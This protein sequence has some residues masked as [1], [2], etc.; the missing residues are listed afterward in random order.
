MLN[1]LAAGHSSKNPVFQRLSFIKATEGR[2]GWVDKRQSYR[3][4][5]LFPGSNSKAVLDQRR[6]LVLSP[7]A[8][9][10]LGLLL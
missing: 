4:C 2:L 7:V 6:G 3:F 8:I 1:R 5:C 9:L 10:S